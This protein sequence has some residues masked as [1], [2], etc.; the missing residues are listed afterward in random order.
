[1][2]FIIE[3]ALRG[4][5]EAIAR[6]QVDMALATEN[7]VLDREKVLRGVRTVFEKRDIGF[8][9]VAKD[10]EGKPAGSLLI[11]KEW[12]DWRNTE[13]WWIHSV[14]VLPEYRRMGIFRKMFA[15]AESLARAEGVFALRLFVEKNNMI[16]KAVYCEAGMSSSHYDLLE[17]EL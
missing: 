2:D 10:S 8:Y 11:Q 4:D 6:F 17:K 5:I 12:S 15:Y 7:L 14:Y 1:M 16:A 9:L 3:K 13:A